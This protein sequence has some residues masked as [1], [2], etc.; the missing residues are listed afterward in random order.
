MEGEFAFASDLGGIGGFILSEDGPDSLRADEVVS[1][2][3]PYESNRN[4][5]QDFTFGSAEFLLFTDGEDGFPVFEGFP[6]FEEF[7]E[8]E[9]HSFG[10]VAGSSKGELCSELFPIE[11]LPFGEFFFLEE[12]VEFGEELGVVCFYS[13]Q[14]L[15]TTKPDTV[16]VAP[17]I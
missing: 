5:A 14:P 1:E 7:G 13:L 12:G 15:R 2:F 3:I 17:V 6:I 16:R 11:A 9:R 4:F 8:E 10:Q